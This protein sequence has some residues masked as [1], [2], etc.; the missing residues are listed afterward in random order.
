MKIVK[1][2]VAELEIS[3]DSS[4]DAHLILESTKPEIRTAPSERS[5]IHV[6]LENNILKTQIDAKD[7]SSLRASINSYL[8]WIILSYDINLLKKID[9]ETL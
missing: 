3:F 8:R 1:H 4:D 9:E 6:D 2:L 7:I 5:S